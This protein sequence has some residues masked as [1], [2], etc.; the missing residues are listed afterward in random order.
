MK[1]RIIGPVIGFVILSFYIFA[2]VLPLGAESWGKKLFY[3]KVEHQGHIS[4]LLGSIHVFKAEYY[5][6]P[7]IITRGFNESKILV[8]EA[9]ISPKDPRNLQ[10][11]L[12]KHA[13]YKPGDSLR[14]HIN[15]RVYRKLEDWFHKNKLSIQR[16]LTFRPWMMA[17]TLLLIELQKSGFASNY[18]L[19]YNFIRLAAKKKKKIHELESVE[20][21]FKLFSGLDDKSQEIY[22][23]DTLEALNESGPLMEGVLK[24]YM[25]GDLKKFSNT[26]KKTRN[27]SSELQPFMYSIFEERNVRMSN[28]I[29]RLLKHKK[30]TYFIVVGAGHMVGPTGIVKSLRRK[31]YK[32]T[33]M[34]R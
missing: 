23:S 11:L 18:G 19:D 30:N 6:L 2:S 26:F 31:G 32:V 24:N 27:L 29:D 21:Q 33:R 17:N 13:L 1:K 22:L 12:R 20:Q 9:N 3:W 34:S 4:Y 8:V 28:H 15:S 10:K 5:P 7:T 25:N 16:F 14:N